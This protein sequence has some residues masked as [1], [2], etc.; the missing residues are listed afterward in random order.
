[1]KLK[2][3]NLYCFDNFEIDF[4]YPKK[5]VNSKVDYEFLKDRP[6]FRFKRVNII[7]G[8]NA[9]GKTSLG[10]L[11][12][13]IIGIFSDGFSNLF[14]QNFINIIND[15]NNEANFE[16]Y[17]VLDKLFL[18]KCNGK[19]ENQKLTFFNINN[20]LIGKNDSFEN[21]YDKLE[22]DSN[23]S[24]NLIESGTYKLVEYLKEFNNK[25]E[26]NFLFSTPTLLNHN[27]RNT[28][29]SLHNADKSQ[30]FEKI[31]NL[32]LKTFDTSISK[33]TKSG[34]VKNTFNI[35]FNNGE[36]L[37]IQN[38]EIINKSRLSSGTIEGIEIAYIV[39][40]MIIHKDSLFFIDEIF[41][42][43][44]SDLEISILNILIEILGCK[45]QLFFTTHNTD[46]LELNLPIHSFTFLRK[47]NK[48]E[49]LDP[50]TIIKKNDRT[51]KNAV[52]NDV[53]RTL[54]NT[55]L[56]YEILEVENEREQ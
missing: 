2:A 45:S 49:V 13:K 36:Q 21:T 56:L 41:L 8:A 43:T 27:D 3:N 16:I 42:C 35:E 22:F 18:Y 29:I 32:V 39:A 17:F 28:K 9:S 6:N 30:I 23:T 12:F 53:F 14:T 1:M 50:S 7:M 44:Q 31:L 11:I 34:E 4:S 24:I 26:I 40:Y 54:P 33:I 10:Q 51:L 46:I 55:D 38:G 19:F 47:T 15:K 37:S 5:L 25:K 48:I 52:K 20:V